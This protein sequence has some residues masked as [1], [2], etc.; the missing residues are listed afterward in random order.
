MKKSFVL[1]KVAFDIIQR[2][3]A[4]VGKL[5]NVIA[6]CDECSL[7]PFT[8]F[9]MFLYIPLM[10]LAVE[11]ESRS[12]FTVSFIF[13]FYPSKIHQNT[14]LLTHKT[15]SPFLT[16]LLLALLI[17]N[18]EGIQ[19]ISRDF[20]CSVCCLIDYQTF[21]VH[22]GSIAIFRQNCVFPLPF[23]VCCCLCLKF[24]YIFS[25]NSVNYRSSP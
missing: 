8:L 19:S 10:E 6:L 16:F 12:S 7:N 21:N 4:S 22:D 13:A 3:S 24:L 15:F 23:L 2:F 20:Y 11:Q 14:K 18:C 25:P 9:I 1:V 17:E 5:M